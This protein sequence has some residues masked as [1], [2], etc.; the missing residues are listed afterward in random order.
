MRLLDGAALVADAVAPL[1][2][3]WVGRS[4]EVVGSSGLGVDSSHDLDEECMD[5]EDLGVCNKATAS[6]DDSVPSR[7]GVL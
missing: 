5:L 4:G 2:H 3:M 7:L 6:C 1:F